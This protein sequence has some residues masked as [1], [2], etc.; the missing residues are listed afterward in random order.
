M[1]LK[2]RCSNTRQNFQ[3]KFETI[4]VWIKTLKK[5]R[6]TKVDWMKKKKANVLFSRCF[7]Q[8]KIIADTF[9]KCLGI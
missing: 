3:R 7:N 1:D 8:L 6:I 9:N 4:L 5:K 2:S